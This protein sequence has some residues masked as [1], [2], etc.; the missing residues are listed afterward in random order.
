MKRIIDLSGSLFGLAILS[1]LLILLFF[2]VWF[3]LGWPVFFIQERP[4][5]KC[6][7]FRII[8]FRTMT[9]SSD[10]HGNML[11]DQMRITGL[12]RIMRKNSLDEISELFN[13]LKGDMSLVGPRPLLTKY[14]PYF[15][16]REKT[17]L[18]MRPGITG[19]AQV[20]GRNLLE[21]DDRLE[22]DV[23][24]VENFSIWL[25]IKILFITVINVIRQRG[26][27]A[28]SSEFV[29]DFDD[30]RKDQLK[31]KTLGN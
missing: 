29:P 10:P 31:N 18:E 26:V 25:D 3:K 17:R 23:Q 4:G 24:Y 7:P 11:P 30:Y 9:H 19:L 6:N 2:M 12:G 21:W 5:K 27:L 1:P 14:L 20:S 13:V 16:E 22:V 28:V 8:K 15:T